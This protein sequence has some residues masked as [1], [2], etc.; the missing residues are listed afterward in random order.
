MTSARAVVDRVLAELAERPRPS[1]TY[2]LQLTPSFGFRDAAR[3]VPYLAELGVS[4]VYLSPIFAAAPGSPHGYDVVDHNVIRD[5]LGGEAGYA[6]LHAA[7]AAAGLDL[8]LDFVPNHMGI[9]P[10]NPWWIDVLENG[11]SSVYAPFFDI[12]WKP[13]KPELE[14]RVLVPVLGDQFGEVLER[15]ELRLEREGGAFSIAYYDHRFP[16]AP[17]SIPRILGHHLDELRAQ[18]PPEDLDVMELMSIITQLEKM[19]PRHFVDPETVAERAREKEVAKRRLAALFEHSAAIRRHVDETIAFFN[20]RPGDPASYDHLEALL[21]AQAYRLA[22]WR[23][24]GEEINYRRFFDINELAAIRMEDDVVF[25]R[26]HRLLIELLA[27]GRAGGARIDHPDGLSMPTRYFRN[28]QEAYV[29]AMAARAAPELGREELVAEVRR[30]FDDGRAVS[31]LYVVVE[32]ILGGD[33]RMPAAWCVSGTTGYEFLNAVNGLFVERDRART[34]Q[35]LYWRFLEE[36]PEFGR[37]VYEAKRLIM[38]SSMASEVNMLSHRLNRISERNRKTRD[39]TL[40]SIAEALTQVVACLPIYRT[41]VEGTSSETID[42]RDRRYV[43]STIAQAKRLTPS[44]NASLFDFL[45]DIILLRHPSAT[46]ESSRGEVVEFVRKLQQLTGPVTAKAVEDTAF[47][48]YNRLLSL[49]E[50]GGEPERFG[51]TVDEFHRLCGERLETWPGSLNTTSTHDT[52]RSEDVRLRIDALSEVPSDWAERLRRFVRLARGLKVQVDGQ[53]CPERN[54]ELFLYQTLVGAFPDE[55]DPAWPRTHPA[56]VS[57]IER[58]QRYMEKAV[59]EA[60]VRSTWT[61]PNVAYDDAVKAFVQAVL[62]SE[63]FVAELAPFARRLAHA[64]HISSLS[65]TIVKIAAPGVPD[66]YQGCE[67]HDLSLV[68]P[69]N[70]RPVDFGQRETALAELRRRLAEGPDGRRALAL[71]Y[72]SGPALADGRAKLLAV[73]EALRF[74]RD[75]RDLFLQGAYIPLH[76]EGPHAN[77]VIAFARRLG[78]R[79]AVCVAP[80]LLLR[81][82]TVPSE[83]EGTVHLPR[84]MSRELACVISGQRVKP[85]GGGIALS[86]ALAGFPVTLLTM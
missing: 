1:A 68:D 16:V 21:E 26:T 58:M 67:L 72:A 48:R 57:F 12:D 20:G 82:A 46:A 40:N 6:E 32:K 37:I 54:D 69:D 64:A 59:R 3:V 13:V 49:N 4:H 70:R 86:D 30:A 42:A 2:R 62:S 14:H 56:W 80:R 74:R 9:G 28:L 24:A 66:I 63:P 39:F 34:M 85:L 5:E 36:E 51:R 33:E 45:R 76:V 43:H 15:G 29:V 44:L 61:N 60:K 22:H 50:V 71:E 19:P 10:T 11:P 73:T 8:L 31:P 23:V 52:K 81:A 18:L 84:E 78:R 35:G 41:Y 25:E 79:V 47:Y 53:P 7:C 38:S 83:W 27:S 75:Q 65:Q 55:L 77:H 17:R